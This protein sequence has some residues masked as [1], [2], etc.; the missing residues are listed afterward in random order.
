M[1][2][3]RSELTEAFRRSGAQLPIPTE[4]IGRFRQFAP[5]RA[6]ERISGF[7]FALPTKQQEHPRRIK[8]LQETLDHSR[9]VHATGQAF[10]LVCA[11]REP[12]AGV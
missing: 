12:G 8:F 7:K 11:T 3:L 1:P 10:A 6:E 9:N 4:P 5:D 2:S